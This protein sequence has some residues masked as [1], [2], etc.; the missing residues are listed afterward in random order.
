VV[1]KW[2][3]TLRLKLCDDLRSSVA[4][5]LAP[6]HIVPE[7]KRVDSRLHGSADP[8]SYISIQVTQWLSRVTTHFISMYIN[9]MYRTSL[10]R[11]IT[12]GLSGRLK[13][14]KSTVTI[15]NCSTSLLVY[16]NQVNYGRLST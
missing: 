9:Q 7:I 3:F 1:S 13:T 10:A 8:G 14:A 15:V 16:N 11:S 5:S 12:A 6:R 4:S 2:L